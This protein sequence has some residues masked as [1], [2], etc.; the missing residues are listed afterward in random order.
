[1]EG[2]NQEFQLVQRHESFPHQQKTWFCYPTSSAQARPAQSLVTFSSW[3]GYNSIGLT[4]YS[5]E[6]LA[7]TLGLWFSEELESK[8]LSHLFVQWSIA[9]RSVK[10]E[11]K[12]SSGPLDSSLICHQAWYPTWI[13]SVFSNNTCLSYNHL[14]RMI[15]WLETEV[16]SWH[17]T[18]PKLLMQ[19]NTHTCR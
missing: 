10:H 16:R 11:S 1:M 4:C 15:L 18:S 2:D 13:E 14:M 6:K 9:C 19:G 12:Q 5:L 8:V 7:N 17:V 3:R